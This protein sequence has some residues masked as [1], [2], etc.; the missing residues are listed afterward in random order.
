MLAAAGAGGSDLLP[1]GQRQA[2]TGGP[3]SSVTGPGGPEASQPSLP[4]R[5]QPVAAAG[6]AR[7][8]RAILRLLRRPRRCSRQA[9]KAIS[10]RWIAAQDEAI[11]ALHAGHRQA[12]PDRRGAASRSCSATSKST[13]PT[14]ERFVDRPECRRHR[15]ARSPASAPRCR[16]CAPGRRSSTAAGKTLVPGLWDSHMHVGD[17]FNGSAK[18]RSA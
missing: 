15:T 12:L 7:R 2:R 13:T 3:A 16:S 9:M 1:S 11:A 18:L 6:L 5:D 4:D 17:D 10:R 8:P 14:S